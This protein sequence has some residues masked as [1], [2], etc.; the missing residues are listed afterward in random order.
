MMRNSFVYKT[1]C[2]FV[3]SLNS[4]AAGEL[5][6]W[7]DFLLPCITYDFRFRKLEISLGGF[8]ETEKNNLLIF[9]IH[10][11]ISIYYHIIPRAAYL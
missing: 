2:S 3:A 10:L 7:E 1:I 9:F 8:S 6:D 11:C 5:V 4:G